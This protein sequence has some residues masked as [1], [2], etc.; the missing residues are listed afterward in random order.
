MADDSPNLLFLGRSSQ[1]LNAA[2]VNELGRFYAI[3]PAIERVAES[4]YIMCVNCLQHQS[5]SFVR[6]N[7]AFFAKMVIRVPKGLRKTIVLIDADFLSGEAQAALRRSIEVNNHTTR[8]IITT[9]RFGAI[10]DP[11]L[12][13]FKTIN[14][15][16]PIEVQRAKHGVSSSSISTAR[17]IRDVDEL[18]AGGHTRG[19]VDN[20]GRKRSTYSLCL[21]RE[22]CR[23]DYLVSLYATLVR[24]H[25]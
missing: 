1:E 2:V 4:P 17:L 20:D 13:R 25:D 9:R 22:G 19:I 7:L 23:C 21:S 15:S 6:K 12:S 3:D 18:V 14:V 24:R 8:F 10:Q 16:F 11:I 5:I